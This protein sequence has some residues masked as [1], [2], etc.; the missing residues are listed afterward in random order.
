[1]CGVRRLNPSCS[2]QG[3]SLAAE[4]QQACRERFAW[5]CSDPFW[6]AGIGKKHR[7]GQCCC[8]QSLIINNKPLGGEVLSAAGDMQ[9]YEQC[10]KGH[11]CG[12]AQERCRQHV[13]CCLWAG[14]AEITPALPLLV[15]DPLQAQQANERKAKPSLDPPGRN[16]SPWSC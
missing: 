1:M 9:I 7:H 13:P 14:R 12:R 11:M 3:I 16:F 10:H 5:V 2:F 8:T 4:L 6:V 15:G